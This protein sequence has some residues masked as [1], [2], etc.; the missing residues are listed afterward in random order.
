MVRGDHVSCFF[1]F[2]FSPN[3][4]TGRDPPRSIELIYNLSLYEPIFFAIPEA[5]SSTLSG[6]PEPARIGW[7]TVL[8]LRYL[9]GC[10]EQKTC[11]ELPNPHPIYYEAVINDP[12]CSSRL[13]LAAALTPYK[14]LTYRDKKRK[15]KP[16][17]ELVIRESLKLGSQSHF[18]DGIPPLF[19]AYNLIA[20]SVSDSSKLHSTSERVGIGV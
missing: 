19:T 11:S 20:S 4:K 5:F 6:V 7:T 8:I 10:R 18:L 16:L 13:Y 9:F 14:R 12:T 17:V 2:V 3:Q 15:E 1:V